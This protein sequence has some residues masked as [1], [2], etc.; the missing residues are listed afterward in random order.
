MKEYK[1]YQIPELSDI[2]ADIDKYWKDKRMMCLLFDINDEHMNCDLHITVEDVEEACNDPVKEIALNA[3]IMT[4]YKF[5]IDEPQEVE[6][7]GPEMES[8][9][10]MDFMNMMDKLSRRDISEDDFHQF[11]KD[12][13]EKIGYNPDDYTDCDMNDPKVLEAIDKLEESNGPTY[14]LVNKIGDRVYFQRNRYD[15][16]M[17]KGE[18]QANGPIVTMYGTDYIDLL[19]SG[20]VEVVLKKKVEL[21]KFSVLRTFIDEMVEKIDRG[22]LTEDSIEEY[23]QSKISA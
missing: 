6:E 5:F 4:G 11:E 14:L 17:Y 3:S 19:G 16:V 23:I 8:S 22:E 12:L 13:G 2:R 1:G 20:T 15:Y 10:M 21:P 7:K 9:M 18:V